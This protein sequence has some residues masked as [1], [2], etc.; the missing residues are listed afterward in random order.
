MSR[1][2]MPHET[3]SSE[4]AKLISKNA[5]QEDY[6]IELFRLL[7]LITSDDLRQK[8]LSSI[9][10]VVDKFLVEDIV[11]AVGLLLLYRPV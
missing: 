7:Q 4:M 2:E 9:K 3:I 5:N 1:F 11:S 8:V 10:D 6:L